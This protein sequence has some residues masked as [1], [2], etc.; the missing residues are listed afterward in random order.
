MLSKILVPTDGSELSNKAVQGAV[1]AA[2]KL[3]ARLVGL[4]VTAPYPVTT[5]TYSRAAIESPQHYDE[6]MRMEAEQHLA[7]LQSAAAAAGVK[8]DTVV[9]SSTSPYEAIIET[10]KSEGCDSIFM[11]SHGRSGLR[12][13]LMGSETNKVLTHTDIPV[14]VFR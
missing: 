2:K 14:L 3:N 13:L 8:L 12:A 5:S 6:R 1:E 9:R 10:A 4:T 11:A 7:P